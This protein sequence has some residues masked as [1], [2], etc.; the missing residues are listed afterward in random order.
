MSDEAFELIRNNDDTYHYPLAPR[1]V[2]QFLSDE[3]NLVVVS[4]PNA[5]EKWG[6]KDTG[7][8]GVEEFAFFDDA[9]AAAAEIVADAQA[10]S[11]DSMFRGLGLSDKEWAFEVSDDYVSLTSVGHPDISILASTE[12]PTWSL[13]VGTEIM[14]EDDYIAVVVSQAN[15]VISARAAASPK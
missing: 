10:E 15:E 2:A 9:Q 8:A 6:V 3:P 4:R 5:L 11:R 13:S 14:A 1:T 12:Y 7:R